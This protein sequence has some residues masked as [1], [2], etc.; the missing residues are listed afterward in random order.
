L[1]SF[2]PEVERVLAV[3]SLELR[4]ASGSD[5]E[6][7]CRLLRSVAHVPV[8]PNSVEQVR[9]GL[10]DDRENGHSFEKPRLSWVA[11]MSD[12]GQLVGYVVADLRDGAPG[13]RVVELAGYVAQCFQR[14]G[15]GTAVE[16]SVCDWLANRFGVTVQEAMIAADNEPSLRRVRR[17]GSGWRPVNP[18]FKTSQERRDWRCFQRQLSVP[19]TRPPT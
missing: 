3:G 15:H 13:H 18:L 10:E 11:P 8:R 17:P 7:V 12:T 4:Q 16:Q 2:P 14:H 1:G 5:A 9:Q 6:E 19:A